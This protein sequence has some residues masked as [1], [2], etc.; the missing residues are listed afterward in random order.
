[1]QEPVLLHPILST[2]QALLIHQCLLARNLDPEPFSESEVEEQRLRRE[3]ADLVTFFSHAMEHP[4]D[5][6]LRSRDD[7]KRVLRAVKPRKGPAKPKPKSRRKRHQLRKQSFAKRTRKQKREEAAQYNEAVKTIEAEQ[8]EAQEAYE[9]EV[10]RRMARFETLASKETVTSDELLEV[11]E[12]FGAP[13]TV[14]ERVRELRDAAS[15]QGR[16]DAAARAAAGSAGD[17]AS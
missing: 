4:E 1:M 5:F 13:P 6:P 14:A 9:A 7:N 3:V 12:L 10:Q 16:I 11:L 8:K 17:G 2:E 15:P